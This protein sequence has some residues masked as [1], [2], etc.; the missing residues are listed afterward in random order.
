MGC[1]NPYKFE[2]QWECTFLNPFTHMNTKRASKSIFI[3]GLKSYQLSS[4]ANSALVG[5]LGL[6][7]KLV[8]FKAVHKN[9]F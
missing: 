6:T 1:P 7:A 8:T 5:R 2:Q 4:K 9:F 3:D